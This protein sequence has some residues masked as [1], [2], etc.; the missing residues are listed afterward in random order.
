MSRFVS[1][2]C[3]LLFALSAAAPS[4]GRASP[5][6]RT[7]A[8]TV[9]VGVEAG[10]V[11]DVEDL[12]PDPDPG[13][14]SYL[15]SDTTTNVHI[16]PWA[17]ARLERRAT[18]ARL[19]G[20]LTAASGRAQAGVHSDLLVGGRLDFE[21]GLGAPDGL[22]AL[23]ASGRSSIGRAV[24]VDSLALER[25]YGDRAGVRT[26]QF[27]FP[28]RPAPPTHRSPARHCAIHA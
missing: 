7:A 15:A 22:V 20:H 14:G 2:L 13:Y 23:E 6:D 26:S 5:D 1:R 8:S 27:I 21:L 17:E 16:Q 10:V 24:W 11:H 12:T 9:E 18:R 19:G 3:K 28:G 25:L 4:V